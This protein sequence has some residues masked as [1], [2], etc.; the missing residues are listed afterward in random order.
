[1][2]VNVRL[3]QARKELVEKYRAVQQGFVDKRQNYE[4]ETQDI[5]A[6]TNKSEAARAARKAAMDA[7]MAKLEMDL[8]DKKAK[9]AFIGALLGG[10]SAVAG[11]FAGITKAFTSSGGAGKDKFSQKVNEKALANK[12][13]ALAKKQEKLK[14]KQGGTPQAQA[15]PTG[16]PQAQA[17]PTGTPQAQATPT[18]TPQAQA[19]S[20][21]TPQAGK[22]FSQKVGDWAKKIEAFSDALEQLGEVFGSKETNGQHKFNAKADKSKA[23]KASKV[24]KDFA[25]AIGSSFSDSFNMVK[26]YRNL[27]SVLKENNIDIKSVM[28]N[29]RIDLNK[30]NKKLNNNPSIKDDPKSLIELA[31]K[32]QI[33]ADKFK[34]NDFYINGNQIILNSQQRAILDK[35][36]NSQA[37]SEDEKKELENLAKDLG[38]D[39]SEVLERVEQSDKI[40]KA[41]RAVEKGNA[42][43]EDIKILKQLGIVNEGDNSIDKN[44]L[45][46]LKKYFYGVAG[47]A[48]ENNFDNTKQGQL[49]RKAQDNE[50]LNRAEKNP[51]SLN[52]SDRQRLQELGVLNKDGSINKEALDKKKQE[53]ALSDSD[54]ATLIE[55]GVM[56]S[57][58]NID[59]KKA[60]EVKKDAIHA[61]RN[62]SN[63]ILD[64]AVNNKQLSEDELAIL[65]GLG[66][67]NSN[68]NINT[69][70]LNSR[71]SE[72]RDLANVNDFRREQ[73]ASKRRAMREGP[74]LLNSFGILGFN[75]NGAKKLASDIGAYFSDLGSIKNIGDAF[76]AIAGNGDNLLRN[77]ALGNNHDAVMS[78]ANSI[79]D[80]KQ[81]ERFIEI[82]ANAGGNADIAY[83]RINSSSNK[84]SQEL[85]DALDA[86]SLFDIMRG[87]SYEAYKLTRQKEDIS[88]K[89]SDLQDK[90]D[91]EI[92][93]LIEK[94]DNSRP[95]EFKLTN[96]QKKELKNQLKSGNDDLAK[97]YI[98]LAGEQYKTELQNSLA[99]ISTNVNK[100]RSEIN[101]LNAKKNDL[102]IRI[103]EL[104]YNFMQAQN[105]LETFNKLFDYSYQKVE[106]EMA[107]KV[108]E[109]ITEA[110]KDG[111]LT[112][113]E[114]TNIT[115]KFGAEY[116][117][118]AFNMMS[119]EQ[120]ASIVRSSRE[121]VK[122]LADF[123]NTN[124]NAEAQD[125]KNKQNTN[126][127]TADVPTGA[128][129]MQS[130]GHVVTF[131][132]STILA[133]V[134]N[135][136]TAPDETE[137]NVSI[138]NSSLAKIMAAERIADNLNLQDATNRGLITNN[139]GNLSLN[140]TQEQINELAKDPNNPENKAKLHLLRNLGLIDSEN[141]LIADPNTRLSEL[142]N[143]KSSSIIENARNSEI[144]QLTTKYLAIASGRGGIEAQS[145]L[146]NMI[147]R[148]SDEQIRNLFNELSKNNPAASASLIIALKSSGKSNMVNELLNND[149]ANSTKILSAL[150]NKDPKI[151]VELF[152]DGKIDNN[153]IKQ[154]ATN[155]PK[156]MAKILNNMDHEEGA[157]LLKSFNLSD[158]QIAKVIGSMDRTKA[159]ELV[160]KGNFSKK[161][162]DS[163]LGASSAAIDDTSKNRD[164]TIA[165]LKQREIVGENGQINQDKLASLLQDLPPEQATNLLIS[166][167]GKDTESI[168]RVLGK[169]A[170]NDAAKIIAALANKTNTNF[171]IS[172]LL[173]R[174]DI[175][176]II[177]NADKET[178]GKFL[179]NVSRNSKV[180]KDA[181]IS[182]FNT[183]SAEKIAD[184]IEKMTDSGVADLLSSMTNLGFEDKVKDAI[185]EFNRNWLGGESSSNIERMGN[186]LLN[187]RS[188]DRQA[189]DKV[190]DN[191][192]NN[193]KDIE[194]LS[195]MVIANQDFGIASFES[196]E[197]SGNYQKLKTLLDAVKKEEYQDADMED[198][199]F[200]FGISNT[201][202]YMFAQ[203][204]TKTQVEL[205]KELNDKDAANILSG[206]VENQS[207]KA[208]EELAKTDPNRVARILNNMSNSDKASYFAAIQDSS[209]QAKVMSSFISQGFNK[210]NFWE[211]LNPFNKGD[212]DYLVGK[213]NNKKFK[214]IIEKMIDDKINNKIDNKD[215]KDILLEVSELMAS[216][217]K[218]AKY[219]VFNSLDEKY[220]KL[221]L[222]YMINNNKSEA[223][224]FLE[225]NYFNV[226]KLFNHLLD[227]NKKSAIDLLNFINAGL[228]GNDND[229][230]LNLLRR[231]SYSTRDKL[232]G[233]DKKIFQSIFKGAS[234]RAQMNFLASVTNK[235]NSTGTGQS[236]SMSEQ[237]WRL[238]EG[239]DIQG[240]AIGKDRINFGDSDLQSEMTEAEE[241]FNKYKSFISNLTNNNNNINQILEQQL[242]QGEQIGG[243]KQDTSTQIRSRGF[244]WI[245][246]GLDMSMAG[247]KFMVGTIR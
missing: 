181:K 201:A 71:I 68:G 184:T 129:I 78:F 234:T 102:S 168:A 187:L 13:K 94:I 240:F 148:L 16:T 60:D 203:L 105:S 219:N 164:L 161:V 24:M 238:M 88:S 36:K 112:D 139:N 2:A 149:K 9:S 227:S 228:F 221:L 166:I 119:P 44:A 124:Y 162:I 141:K 154:L 20:T 47:M 202:I 200:L 211:S 247:I 111:K 179:T 198:K 191:F 117:A 5:A 110:F 127:S 56:D 186:I 246:L 82:M 109:M 171:D 64:K 132:V 122:Q 49:L 140:I 1:M 91:E 52:A 83:N 75:V 142:Q 28:T 180:D 35:V 243:S 222:E 48:V 245:L 230:K 156:A 131:G 97:K 155:D 123:I 212:E 107:T 226:D 101:D 120:L 145:A 11:A 17:T 32:Y 33:S 208:L 10:I 147:S 63:D 165:A 167:Y 199:G 150:A 239:L 15:T 196:L 92:D 233:D 232:F 185:K 172:S 213:I 50:L 206:I 153:I 205:L 27:A 175:Q 4:K 69:E 160:S 79:K 66:L 73:S 46:Q 106:N 242:E 118:K 235:E 134:G 136:L 192:M 103:N 14:A 70:K 61:I 58:G 81:K 22:S 223:V 195:E 80:E 31:M 130:V 209:I 135:A 224:K 204:S 236:Y 125:I 7:K 8:A 39:T 38:V 57:S 104:N 194:Y 26:E 55:M 51:S 188:T 126:F 158:D 29:G 183:L 93:K 189:F 146:N 21:E 37:L 19:T 86:Q 98:S 177:N 229:K 210:K 193:E 182:I 178:L 85:L 18:G 114:F 218:D 217:D 90:I 108:A 207:G 53:L 116:V 67:L 43:E 169:F 74:S 77:R 41:I 25:S 216:L 84:I 137:S 54:K 157:K 100:Y 62:I 133:A 163:A 72:L 115:K 59:V 42:S 6:K 76:R 45:E 128:I 95:K 34:K 225:N 190:I 65:K 143:G 87:S 214:E 121:G 89:I 244:N 170:S 151:A 40:D 176:N 138:K 237:D 30:L 197:Q 144:D 220:Q 241:E 173:Q 96:E 23:E 99:N 3:L 231:L 159:L 152:K 12:E 174:K 215:N 113:E